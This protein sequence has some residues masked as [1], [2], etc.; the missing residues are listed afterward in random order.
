MGFTGEHPGV[1]AGAAVLGGDD[2]RGGGGGDAGEAPG[3]GDE[4]IG[5]GADEAAEDEGSGFELVAIPEGSGGEGDFFLADKL[6]GV[7]LDALEESLLGIWGE[8]AD[9]SGFGVF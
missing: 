6:F 3:E 7:H 9:K 2:R 5:G 1:H 4:A 8:G